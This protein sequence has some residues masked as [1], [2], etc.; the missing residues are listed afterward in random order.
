[1]QHEGNQQTADTAVAVKKWVNRFELHVGERGFDQCWIRGMLVMNEPLKGGHAVLE[2]MRRWRNEMGVARSG[3][4]DPV[5]SSPKFAGRLFAAAALGKQNR[6]HFP[7][8]PV[9]QRKTFAQAIYAVFQRRNVSGNLS[10]IIER[11][12]WTSSSSKRSR[13]ASVD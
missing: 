8:E 7:D 6:V 12:P 1:M 3:P 5:L 2:S 11:H 4:T 10:N 9:R 13:S